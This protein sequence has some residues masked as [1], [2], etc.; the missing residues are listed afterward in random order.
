MDYTHDELSSGRAFRSLNLMEGY[1]QEALGIEVDA[2]LPGLCVV[3]V[4]ERLR[5]RHGAPAAIQVDNDGVH[6]PRG[7]AVGVLA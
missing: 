2:S 5:E 6:Q 1:T 7:G 3:R 4:L